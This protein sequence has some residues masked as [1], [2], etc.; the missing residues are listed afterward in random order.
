MAD[1]NTKEGNSLMQN[2]YITLATI[3]STLAF[4]HGVQAVDPVAPDGPLPGG[5]SAMGRT[6]SKV[7]SPAHSIPQLASI[8]S[9]S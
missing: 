1:Q 2:R 4:L 8:Q 5:N 7:L 9:W 6:P 3:L